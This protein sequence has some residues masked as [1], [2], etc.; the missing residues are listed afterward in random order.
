MHMYALACSKESR[1]ITF[2][3]HSPKYNVPLACFFLYTDI[4]EFS[5]QSDCEDQDKVSLQ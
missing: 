5:K 1:L 4:M 2:N 3:S